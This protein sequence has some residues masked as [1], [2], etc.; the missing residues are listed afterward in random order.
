MKSGEA[1]SDI[2]IALIGHADIVRVGQ[3]LILLLLAHAP[4]L[5]DQALLVAPIALVHALRMP[6]DLVQNF[7]IAPS[8]LHERGDDVEGV[9]RARSL[10]YRLRHA[11]QIGMDKARHR[12]RNL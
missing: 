8:H 3:V 2:L 4:D 10:R 5:L 1:Q 7:V 6:F 11:P 12:R 9:F